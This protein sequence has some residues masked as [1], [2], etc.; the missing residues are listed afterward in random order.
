MNDIAVGAVG[1]RARSITLAALVTA[2]LAA[3]AWVAIP[4]GAVPVTLQVFVVV[5]AALLLPPLT[6]FGALAAYLL[7]GAAGV[8]VFSGGTAGLGVLFGPTGGY[9]T[10][11]LVGA[12]AGAGV[13]T[14]MTERTGRPPTSLVA[15]V[16]AAAT[17]IVL[18]YLLGWFQ[19]GQVTGMDGS[20]AFFAGVAP[21]V[22]VDLVKA[23]VATGVASAVRRAGVASS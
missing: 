13:R 11:F 23:A 2:L 9:L 3:S 22:P 7:L 21:F 16:S 20:A 4:V 1:T 5:L 8:P 17:T 10:G 19:L 6:A 18:I 14:W 15:D 12:W